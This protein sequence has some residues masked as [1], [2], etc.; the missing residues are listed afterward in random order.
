MHNDEEFERMW[1]EML[2]AHNPE[3]AAV[4]VEHVWCAS[5]SPSGP[6]GTFS[7]MAEAEAFVNSVEPLG[8]GEPEICEVSRWEDLRR[9]IPPAFRDAL[10]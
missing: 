6:H 3:G 8:E 2:D 10:D 5:A 7:S 4:V 1:R 9:R